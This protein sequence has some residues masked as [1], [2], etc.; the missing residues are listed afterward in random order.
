MAAAQA[1]QLDQTANG[2]PVGPDGWQRRRFGNGSKVSGAAWNFQARLD[3]RM[4]DLEIG[5]VTNKRAI[6]AIYDS[7]IWKALCAMGGWLQR[8]TGRGA[9]AGRD[10]GAAGR[11]RCR[12]CRSIASRRPRRL[13]GVGMR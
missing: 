3:G 7:R 1:A 8:L 11:S 6:Q 4:R 12:P 5:L 2:R 10:L 9:A 13:P